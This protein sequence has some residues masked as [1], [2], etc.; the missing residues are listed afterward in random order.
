MKVIVSFLTTNFSGLKEFWNKNKSK[1]KGSKFQGT[2]K[3]FNVNL[4]GKL[5]MADWGKKE[6]IKQKDIKTPAGFDISKNKIYVCSSGNKIS[7][8]DLNFKTKYFLS[9]RYLNDLHSLNLI[10]GKTIV[11]TSTGLDCIL[12]LDEKGNLIWS[13]FA[14]EEGYDKDPKGRIRVIDK[15]VDHRYKEY[16]TLQ[17]TTHL[18]SAIYVGKTK[19]FDQTIYCSL[20]H[21]GKI[22]AIDKSSLKHKVILE[23][24]KHPHSIYLMKNKIIISDTENK[25]TILADK[26]L[27]KIKRVKIKGI[28]WIQDSTLLKNG[29]LLIS[30]PDNNRVVEFSLK[31]NKIE[32]EMFFNK[33]WRIYQAKEMEI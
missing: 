8:L 17:Q 16:P 2:D 27:N 19:H 32:G 11:V 9:N 4:G 6:I 22:I 12:I 15:K 33:E 7:I 24:L 25:T 1:K 23:N 13:W 21:Q 14:T 18:N 28:G 26:D 3:I 20:F 30:D 29:N 5:M 10:N 31:D